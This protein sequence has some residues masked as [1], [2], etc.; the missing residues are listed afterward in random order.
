MNKHEIKM[1]VNTCDATMFFIPIFAYFYE[2][3]WKTN[4]QVKVLG[5]SEPTYNLPKRFEYISL[6]SLFIFTINDYL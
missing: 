2:K 4:T 1:Y 5:F 6:I 3:Y